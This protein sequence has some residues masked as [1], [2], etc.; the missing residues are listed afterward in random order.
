VCGTRY[1]FLCLKFLSDDTKQEIAIG[2]YRPQACIHHGFKLVGKGA[3]F[4]HQRDDDILISAGMLQRIS[5]MRI[6]LFKLRTQF[7]DG[8]FQA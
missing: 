2:G 1:L 6:D 5:F 3:Q 4:V 8:G 7:V